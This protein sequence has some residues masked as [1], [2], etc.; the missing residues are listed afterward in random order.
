MVRKVERNNFIV[1]IVLSLVLGI[2]Y[3]TMGAKYF[4]AALVLSFGGFLSLVDFRIAIFGVTFMMPFLPNTLALLAFLGVGFLYFL[5]RIFIEKDTIVHNV[6][7]GIIAVYLVVIIIQTVTSVDFLGSLRDLGLH[8]GGLAYIF[9]VVNT[10]KTRKDFNIFLTVLL[11]SVTIV[12]LIGVLQIFTGVEIRREWVDVEAN[13]D[14][15][16]RVFS[17]FGNPNTL[18]EYL[19]MFTPVGV[20]MFWY[21]K[22]MKKKFVFG[23]AVASMLVCLI[24]TMS[25]GGW[26]GIAMAA[27]IYC[28][29]VDKRLLLLAIPL[30]LGA[31]LFM[32]TSILN[33]IMS[34][35][36]VADSS[37]VHRFNIFNISYAMIKDNFIAGVGLGH[38]P[39]KKVFETYSRTINA[40]HAHNSFIQTF[41]ELGFAGFVLFMVMLLDFI[42]YPIMKL[43]NQT[44]YINRDKY[45]KYIGAGVVAGIIGVFTHGLAENVLYLPKIIFSFWTLV[46]IGAMAVNIVEIN[47]PKIIETKDQVY[48]ILRR[49]ESDD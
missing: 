4:L 16:V 20:G 19:V 29:L 42:R 40:Y 1:P 46:G 3:F 39:F 35:G 18:A 7:S 49:S 38:L 48:K 6:Y 14:M 44:K 32:P 5:R 26:V 47:T 34:I 24:F 9:A 31:L 11:A 23:A 43:I 36:N 21:T 2:I 12:A 28:L 27:L 45:F 30:G 25:R 17:V 15:R 22:D 8:I 37:S 33:R 10:I 13:P 41:A